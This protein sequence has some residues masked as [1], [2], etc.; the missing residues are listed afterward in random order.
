MN[1]SLRRSW[2]D[3]TTVTALAAVVLTLAVVQIPLLAEKIQTEL[4]G[5]NP[6]AEETGAHGAVMPALE[7]PIAPT[8]TEAGLPVEAS[9][10]LA[11]IAGLG[12]STGLGW[13]ESTSGATNASA[14][15]HQG[16]HVRLGAGLMAPLTPSVGV[17]IRG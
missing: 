5:P 11:P 8:S 10:W 6:D 12:M 16:F 15:G 9:V 3:I 13:V 2:K 14:N 17:D 1:R 7:A 4:L